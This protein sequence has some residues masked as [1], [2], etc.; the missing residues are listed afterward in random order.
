[1]RCGDCRLGKP[2]SGGRASACGQ[3]TAWWGG[4]RARCMLCGGRGAKEGTTQSCRTVPRRHQA[5][6]PAPGSC[7]P[8]RTGRTPGSS[9]RSSGLSRDSRRCSRC[10]CAATAS[11][12]ELRHKR[13]GLGGLTR[14]LPA[15]HAPRHVV[16]QRALAVEVAHRRRAASNRGVSTRHRALSSQRSDRKDVSSVSARAARTLQ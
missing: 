15:P 9:A 4:R 13:A 1:M 5:L 8:R 7:S 11:D 6:H 2:L 12:G 16:A 10:T 14:E 3:R